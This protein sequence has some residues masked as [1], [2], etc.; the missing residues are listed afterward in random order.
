MS[1]FAVEGGQNLIKPEHNNE[2]QKSITGIVSAQKQKLIVIN[3]MPEH[4][5]FLIG[6][7]PKGRL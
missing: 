4:V 7:V 5:R 1:F 3:N 6:L 2:L